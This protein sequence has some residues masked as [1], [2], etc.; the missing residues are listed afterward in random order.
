MGAVSTVERSS[1]DLSGVVEQ[2]VRAHGYDV[3]TV[4]EGGKPV[5]VVLS[6][7]EWESIRET[8]DVLSVPGQAEAIAEGLRDAAEGRLSDGP[9][10]LSAYLP[11]R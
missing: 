2:A 8:L 11:S 9:S 6:A 4:T 1:T 10:A 7:A 5:A 3:V